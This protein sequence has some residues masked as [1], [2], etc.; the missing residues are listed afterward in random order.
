MKGIIRKLTSQNLNINLSIEDHGGSF[1][2]P[3]FNPQ[4][5]A[6]FPDLTVREFT[7]LTHLAMRTKRKVDKNECR[8][9]D[10]DDWGNICEVRLKS[11]LEVLKTLLSEL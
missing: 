2:L 9:V 5:L 1:I 11:D 4:F 3:F 10:R 6:E 7:H 8:I